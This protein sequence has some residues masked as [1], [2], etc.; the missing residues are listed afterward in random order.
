MAERFPHD[1]DAVARTGELAERLEFDLTEELGYRY[2]DFSDR[3]SRRSRSSARLRPRLRR[4]ATAARTATSAQARQPA[5]RG[6]EADRGARPRR[7]LPP[8]LGGARAGARVRARGARRARSRAT[9]SRPGRGRGSSVGSI[10]CY[11]TGLSHVDPVARRPSARALPQPR[12]RLGA[13]HRPRLPAR[14]PREADRR[15]SASATAASTRRSSRA[16][17]PTAR[18]A[19]SATSA[20]R[21]ACRSPS[22]SGSRGSRTAARARVGEELAQ[23]PDAETKLRLAAL[24]RVRRA[25]RRDRRPAAPHLAAPGR[26]GDLDAAARR[27][28][29]G[30]AGGDGGPPDLPVGQ[31]LLRRRRLPQDR[32]AR[33]RDALGGR[34][35]RRADRPRCTARR[36]TSRASRSTTRPSTARSSAPTRSA[37]SRSRAGRRCRSLLRTRPENLDDLTVQVA[38]VRPGPIQGG[39]VHPYIEHRRRLR[40]DPSFVPPYDHPLLEEPLRETLGVVVFQEQVLEVAMALA[41]F[42]VGEAEGLRRAMSRKR[43]REAIEAFR[44]RFVEGALGRRAS[45]ARRPSM[46]FEKLVGFSAFGFPK[47]HAAAFALLAYQSAWLRHHYPARVPLRAPERAA[48]GLLPAGVARARRAAARGGG[49]PA[50]R[51]PRARRECALEDGAV[52]VG[53]GYVRALGEEEA[54]ALVAERERGGP[55]AGRARAGAADAARPAAAGGARRLGRLRLVRRQPPACSS[56]SS[57]S[58]RARRACPGAGARSASSR[59]RSTRPRRRPRCPS[60]P[61]GSGCSPTT[62]RRASR[63]ACTRSSCCARTCRR[64]RSRAASSRSA[65]AGGAV[66]VAGMAVARQRPATAN[67]V[68]FMLLEDEHGQMNLIVP[69]PVYERYRAARAR[70]AAAARARAL[71]A[72]RPEPERRRARARVA[73][74]ARPALRRERRRL[75]L[76]PG[77]AP[78]RPSLTAPTLDTRDPTRHARRSARERIEDGEERALR[79]GRF[80]I[81]TPGCCRSGSGT[82]GPQ[83][84]LPKSQS[85]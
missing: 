15:A 48:D 11:L 49:A 6:A 52:R 25:V 2:P 46:V 28:R 81:R 62:G 47:S 26:D 64:G 67:G 12:A 35:L 43:S 22:S 50:G 38:L 85:R 5:R 9:C 51:E 59:C 34:G 7:L 1:R 55:F 40:E 20:R 36:S 14:H 60:R 13:R 31:G 58:C 78:L 76:A 56:G 17:R 71:R 45:T 44:E 84:L 21:S 16:S 83:R 19:R 63:S 80:R 4:S 41:G 3:A 68:V 72:A 79:F 65:P 53:L 37:S 33:A 30:A 10:V 42:T 8:A 29:P 66:A 82:A 27:A 23:L 18:A 54:Q 24:A 70:R 61:P 77:R 32:P 69:P 57:G 75:R 74:P 39:A 73:R